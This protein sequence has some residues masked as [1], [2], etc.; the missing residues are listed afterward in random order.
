MKTGLFF[1]DTWFS[2]DSN[3]FVLSNLVSRCF[4]HLQ[5]EAPTVWF[6]LHLLLTSICAR[7]PSHSFFSAS[8]S[9][10]SAAMATV[11]RGCYWRK[12]ET[13]TLKQKREETIKGG[14]MDI[15]M[16]CY[17]KYQQ[18]TTTTPAWL[19]GHCCH[20]PAVHYRNTHVHWPGC[21]SLIDPDT[22]IWNTWVAVT[23]SSLG[24][25]LDTYLTALIPHSKPK[26]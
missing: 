11:A 1:G 4:P 24:W 15:K 22:L 3:C 9:A 7:R 26:L 21:A 23:P 16:F 2:Q 19:L 17:V 18:V 25:R 6:T 20:T 14:I 5:Q 8:I 10:F 13:V 12:E